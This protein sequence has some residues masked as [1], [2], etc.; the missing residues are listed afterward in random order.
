MPVITTAFAQDDNFK[1]AN[2]KQ[3]FLNDADYSTVDEEIHLRSININPKKKSTGI[4]LVLSLLL[5]GAGHYYLDRMDVGKYFLGIDAINW[6][7]FAGVNLY[8]DKIYDDAR[9]FS[10][11]HAGISNTGRDDDYFSNVGF[12][13]SI[14]EYNN[15]KLARGEFGAI[16][17]ISTHY[18]Y[19]DSQENKNTFESQRK[20][21]ERIENTG[22]IFG[23][24]LVVNRLASAI[25]SIFISNSSGNE[26][27]VTSDIIRNRD[28]S[29]DG[30]MLHLQKNF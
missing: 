20:K 5:P 3:I 17:D 1:P 30:F 8:A 4:A 2:S 27:K 11:I 18:W 9:S 28:N 16:Y 22:I 7:G 14:Y 26:V 15:D 24:A 21:S 10:K 13:N 6:I 23:T 25:S 19:W 12:Y 29:V